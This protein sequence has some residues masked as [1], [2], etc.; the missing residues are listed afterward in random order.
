MWDLNYELNEI[1]DALSMNDYSVGEE[2]DDADLEQELSNMAGSNSIAAVDDSYLMDLDMELSVPT[3]K[4][5]ASSSSSSN[6]GGK[7]YKSSLSS[8]VSIL[9][10]LNIISNLKIEISFEKKNQD[11]ELEKALGL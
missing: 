5:G 8:E 2:I 3:H 1:N 6:S 7:G 10:F 11:R 4:I 9:I